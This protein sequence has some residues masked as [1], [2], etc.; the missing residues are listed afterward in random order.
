LLRRNSRP[1][2]GRP[3]YVRCDYLSILSCCVLSS[4]F[5]PFLFLLFLLS[6]CRLSLLLLALAFFAFFFRPFNQGACGREHPLCLGSSYTCPPF[7][8]GGHFVV[9][10]QPSLLPCFQ[11]VRPCM[12]GVYGARASTPFPSSFP[13]FWPCTSPLGPLFCLSSPFWAFFLPVA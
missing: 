4:P 5:P 9:R 8:H 10:S 7:P 11:A 6:G 12:I 1:P 13:F 2:S 3:A